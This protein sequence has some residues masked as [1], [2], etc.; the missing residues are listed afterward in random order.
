MVVKK[1]RTFKKAPGKKRT[2]A[3]KKNTTSKK[4]VRRPA[5]REE[6]VVVLEAI[7]EKVDEAPQEA[8]VVEKSDEHVEQNVSDAGQD[9]IE[10]VEQA[11][12]DKAD[13]Q[14]QSLQEE[15]SR[16]ESTLFPEWEQERKKLKSHHILGIFTFVLIATMILSGL[17]FYLLELRKSQFTAE[18]SQVPTPTIV[19]H[20]TPTPEVIDKL[21]YSIRI[22]NGSGIAGEA[23]RIRTL[24]DEEG[25]DVSG[26]GNADRYD[27]EDTVVRTKASVSKAY[28]ELLKDVLAKRKSVYSI[29]ELEETSAD[30]IVIIV[31]RTVSHAATI[32]STPRRSN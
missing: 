31:G 7:T 16:G 11:V 12:S 6:S 28:V 15:D 13:S 3:T 19:R 1:K 2:V 8:P 9:A 23:G 20:V 17:F 24:L 5:K 30:D 26:T 21:A 14:E 25:F 27:Y 22:L 18:V 4:T 29:D 32:T 10:E